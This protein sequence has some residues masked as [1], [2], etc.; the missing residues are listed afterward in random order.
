V[1][2]DQICEL[3]DQFAALAVRQARPCSSFKGTSRGF[4]CEINIR[5]VSGGALVHHFPGGWIV[6]W[7]GLTGLGINPFSVD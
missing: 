4:D 7:K 5:L 3:S 6:N 1:I 2:L